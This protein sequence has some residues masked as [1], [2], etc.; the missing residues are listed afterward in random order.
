MKTR[1]VNRR[2]INSEQIAQITHVRFCTVGDA[3]FVQQP[4]PKLRTAT[5]FVEPL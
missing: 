2:T 4:E 1:T 5:N 3:L